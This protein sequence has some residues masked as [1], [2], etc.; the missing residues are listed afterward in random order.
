MPLITPTEARTYLPQTSGD[1]TLISTLIDEAGEMMA[2]YC[3]YARPSAS[4]APTMLSTSYTLFLDSVGRSFVRLPCAPITAVS[5]LYDDPD[6]QYGAATAIGSTYREI[7]G[8]AADTIELLPTYGI[9]SGTEL[10]PTRR[11]I[12]VSVTAGFATADAELKAICGWLVKHLF[13]QR[14][15]GQQAGAEDNGA[16]SPRIPAALRSR[17]GRYMLPAAF[18][19]AS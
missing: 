2:I 8:D 19:G 17:L 10:A 5:A 6:R 11:A 9:F 18:G 1:E 3:G 13:E 16:A 14:R 4:T 12:K 7:A 15:R